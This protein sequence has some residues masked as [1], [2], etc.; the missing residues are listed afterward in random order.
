MTS[1]AVLMIGVGIVWLVVWTIKN[2]HAGKVSDQN[3]LFRMRNWAAESEPEN[4]LDKKKQSNGRQFRKRERRFGRNAQD[5]DATSTKNNL[6]T[7]DKAGVSGVGQPSR[8]AVRSKRTR[9]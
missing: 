6:S 7:N 1:I 9:L 3:G 2:E 8:T 5:E 4:Q